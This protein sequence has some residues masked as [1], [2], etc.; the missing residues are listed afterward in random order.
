[1]TVSQVA[2]TLEM[3]PDSVTYRS[4]TDSSLIVVTPRDAD[5]SIVS[6]VV[7]WTSS[8]TLVARIAP[9]GWLTS[10]GNGEATIAAML[11]EARDSIFVTVSQEPSLIGLSSESV[12]FHSWE[13]TVR[14]QAS[15]TD[16]LGQRIR[17]AEVLWASSNEQVAR[18][19][20]LGLI[21]S[22]GN[23]VMTVF[24]TSGGVGAQVEVV[25]LDRPPEVSILTPERD[26][27]FPHGNYVTFSA[28][29]ADTVEGDLSDEIRWVSSLSGVLGEGSSIAVDLPTGEHSVTAI[30][31]DSRDQETSATRTVNVFVPAVS[32]V[33]GG[34]SSLVVLSDGTL[35][36]TGANNRGG[37]GTGT[38]DMVLAFIPVMSGVTQVAIGDNYSL[39]LKSDGSLWAS[40]D[41]GGGGL[42]RRHLQLVGNTGTGERGRHS[43]CYGIWV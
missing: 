15:V 39:R 29:A 27:I 40:G 19:D 21:T 12:A 41:N 18:V 13:D 23:G 38:F 10:V 43:Y 3:G 36:A 25:V 24:A 42:R 2:V 35:L 20:S 7:Q 26:T 16:A 31:A 30:V 37:L 8:D 33:A 32:V 28:V 1:M 5:G 34:Q 11:D 6:K 17:D 22:V 4:L 9:T 14:V